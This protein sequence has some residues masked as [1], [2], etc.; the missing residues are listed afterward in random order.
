MAYTANVALGAL[1]VKY[2][3]LTK[4]PNALKGEL[5]IAKVIMQCGKEVK[6]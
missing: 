5:A 2:D 6:K 1:T 3:G 4:A